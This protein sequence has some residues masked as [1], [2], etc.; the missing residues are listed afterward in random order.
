MASPSCKK[1]KTLE[2]P[3][4]PSDSTS[5]EAF[6]ITVADPYRPL[7][8][9]TSAATRAWVEAENSLTNSYLQAIPFRA[10]LRDRLNTLNSYERQGMPSRE[11]DGRYYFS[12]NDGSRNQSIVYRMDSI[13]G[14]PEVFI[15]P[16]TL[17]DDG[18]VALTGLSFSKDGR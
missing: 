8:N 18:T 7:E 16:N 11:N 4:A 12:A 5:Y 3:A 13:G 15:D 9:D 2:Y 10:T 1:G 14:T 6:D 17:S